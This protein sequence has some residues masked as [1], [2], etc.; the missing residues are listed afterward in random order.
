MII[1]PLAAGPGQKIL[2]P[3]RF[4]GGALA[5]MQEGHPTNPSNRQDGRRLN[6]A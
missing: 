1:Y 2:W 6:A 3:T 4:N 5:F